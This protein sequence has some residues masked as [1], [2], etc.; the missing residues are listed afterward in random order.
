[1]HTYNP[2]E[3]PEIITN[4]I[5]NLSL[6]DLDRICWINSIWYKEV[7]QELRKRCEKRKKIKRNESWKQQY[8]EAVLLELEK[9]NI[10]RCMLV[11]GML[12]GKEKENVTN[13]IKELINESD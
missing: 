12:S 13:E 3:L 9:I 11:N 5:R 7:Q 1:M 10:K 2:L 4:I 8:V 6:H